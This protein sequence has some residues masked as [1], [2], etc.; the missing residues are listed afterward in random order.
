MS[1]NYK[2]NVFLKTIDLVENL[3]VQ[4]LPRTNSVDLVKLLTIS[5]NS[6]SP[7]FTTLKLDSLCTYSSVEM[8]INNGNSYYWNSVISSKK[9][10]PSL[11]FIY[12]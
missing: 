12:H 1:N 10:S 6:I 11:C 5:L 2:C 8:I 4:M 7:N 3:E 9:F